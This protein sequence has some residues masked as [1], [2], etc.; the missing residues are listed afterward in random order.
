ML[1]P[2]HPTAHRTSFKM[3]NHWINTFIMAAVDKIR[4]S[5]EITDSWYGA[6]N[7]HSGHLEG[8]P[9]QFQPITLRSS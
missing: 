7:Q 3:K 4:G 1:A 9:V 8:T 6:V 5:L 2:E